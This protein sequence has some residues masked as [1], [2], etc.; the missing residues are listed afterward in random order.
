MFIKRS[1]ASTY[2][3]RSIIMS[4]IAALFLCLQ[5]CGDEEP[6]GLK[7][8]PKKTN[9]ANKT[10]NK[11][12]K[13]PNRAGKKGKGFD[14]NVVLISL[15]TLRADHL[16]VYGY[17][18]KVSP[19]IDKFAKASIVF[20][21]AYSHAPW[22]APAHAAMLTSLYPSVLGLK[23]YPTVGRIADKVET[24]AEYFKSQG[25]RTYAVTEGGWVHA[26]FGFD[27]GFEKY[28]QSAKH[29]QKGVINAK[30][31]IQE[32]KK[33][34]F[35]LFF[36]T[37]DIH[38]YNPP[39]EFRKGIVPEEKHRFAEDKTLAKNI[40]L[41][42]NEE[43][44][45]TINEKDKEYIVS[46]YDASI[47]YV[48][49][50]VGQLIEYLG[51]SGLLKN[52]IVVITSD[53]GEEFWENGRTGHGYTN[54]EEQIKVPMIIYHPKMTAGR[55]RG[56]FRHIDLLPTLAKCLN[57]PVRPSWLGQSYVD[58]MMNPKKKMKDR[59][60]FCEAGH[61]N[62]K[63]I[64][65]SKWKLVQFKG[66]K[67]PK[68]YDLKNDP[69]EIKSVFKDNEAVMR[70]LK[71]TLTE[72]IKINRKL[73]PSFTEKGDKTPAMSKKLL[74]QMRKLGYVK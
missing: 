21:N 22:T 55:R 60:N 54:R 23:K 57:R 13:K 27:Q 40:Q 26:R 17:N 37:Y 14:Y 8:Q 38:R 18:K 36:H 73:Q 45:K 29:V 50:Y 69:K 65:T 28:F 63:S 1:Q 67:I 15:D 5:S 4:L 58:Y 48:D 33:D 11:L 47:K 46:L 56:V 7:K 12:G 16:G 19:K 43:F 62:Y 49:N 72:I 24:M 74:E 30:K 32:N 2:I 68:L 61:K 41:L 10:A 64:Q 59:F 42:E 9:N 70:P 44:L 34:K 25:Y 66:E 20:N 53:H 71:Q 35:F 3:H 31:W 6:A 39:A 51:K 52:T